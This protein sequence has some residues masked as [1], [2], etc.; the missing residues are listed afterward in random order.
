[1]AIANLLQGKLFS[2]PSDRTCMGSRNP[3]AIFSLNHQL[4]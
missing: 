1:M 4:Y 2:L 3:A